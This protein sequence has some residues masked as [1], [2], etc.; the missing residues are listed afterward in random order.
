MV[1]K[2]WCLGKGVD[3]IIPEGKKNIPA[4]NT[5]EKVVE[6]VVEKVVEKVVH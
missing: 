2:R 3:S 4:K 5:E 1:A 6:I